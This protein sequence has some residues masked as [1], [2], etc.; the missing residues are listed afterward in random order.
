MDQA[1][2]QK[3]MSSLTTKRDKLA[4][5]LERLELALKSTK[6]PVAR[7]RIEDEIKVLRTEFSTV[8]RQ[9][10]DLE[11]QRAD[12]QPLPALRQKEL[13]YL[14]G[15]IEEYEA[16]TAVYAPV[17]IRGKSQQQ[18]VKIKPAAMKFLTM[19]HNVY[20]EIS[21]SF[22]EDEG[23]NSF[24]ITSLEALLGIIRDFKQIALIGEPGS[25]KT[26][27]LQRIAHELASRAKQHAS[28]PLPVLVRLGNYKGSDVSEF[29][30]QFFDDLPLASYLPNRIILL[31]DGLNEMPIEQVEGI[32]VWLRNNDNVPVVVSCRRADYMERRLPLKRVDILPL[33]IQQINDLIGNFFEDFDRDQL[34]WGLAG[35][36]ARAAWDW[37][38][39]SYG[40][41]A[42][43]DGFW[44]GKIDHAHSW[45]VEKSALRDIQENLRQHGALPGVLGLV[46][47]PFLLVSTIVT[48]MDNQ[49]PPRNRGQLFDKFIDLLMEKRGRICVTPE[50]PWIDASTQRAYLSA[51]AYK[52]LENRY[53]TEV[54]ESWVL[55]VL[56][57]ICTTH[58]PEDVLH[59]GI[60]AGILESKQAGGV[61]TV[62]F[63]HQLLQEY[64]AALRMSALIEQV[65]A[66]K[67]WPSE[68][69]WEPTGWEETV[70][71]LSGILRDATR[72]VK[73]LAPVNPTL[74][75]RCATESGASCDPQAMQLLYTPPEGAR[76]SPLARAAWGRILAQRGDLRPGVG[77]DS[78]GLPDIV[79]CEVPPGK[80][81]MGGDDELKSLGLSWGPSQEINL[82]YP[83]WVSKYPVTYAQFGA[84]LKEG[85][86]NREFWTAAGWRW[87][88]NQQ[89][90]RY[91][92]SVVYNISNHP[93]V[94]V[95]W[96]E[97]YAFTRWLDDMLHLAG[98]ACPAPEIAEWE[99]SLPL[100]AEWEKAA[101]FPDGRR[102]PWGEKYIPGYANIDETYQDAECGPYF[103]RRTTAVGMYEAGR[104]Y[105]GIYDMCGNVWEWCLS[106][107]D[108]EYKY[109]ED[110]DPEGTEHR[111]L[112]GGSWYNSVQFA[113]SA[114]HDCLD[115]DL[116]VNDVGFR[117]VLRP[118]KARS[119]WAP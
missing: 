110:A 34:F 82:D 63:A 70:L 26:A 106:K 67:Y 89:R 2:F 119:S 21:H 116:G 81:S 23:G 43:F 111:G 71:F 93:V 42:T 79:W 102:Y 55:G 69:W 4:E 52:I 19:Y 9:I 80:F 74:A 109:P 38:R 113:P 96:Y 104:S 78:I 91:W 46:T 33:N 76:A 54:P 85:Y 105:L 68:R 95:T 88:G 14:Q 50:H 37:Y 57:D 39:N 77:L 3:Q 92:D 90:P 35:T 94:G 99:I 62:R 31:L 51:L 114:A 117:L 75:F 86:G 25:G 60:G 61:P 98:F 6:A 12:D 45:E 44:F 41:R 118:V 65:G 103:L 30:G 24:T 73:W 1:L 97:S 112:R 83:Y 40:F 49:E 107:W 87:K 59:L 100:E 22:D 20:R 72:V 18:T 5:D 16:L 8:V 13:D 108:V 115:P 53:G 17:H 66:E 11:K 56:G 47:N 7:M 15:L 48:F 64:F 27:T 84:F 58:R 28:S 101:R 36:E 10:G 32:S 29:F